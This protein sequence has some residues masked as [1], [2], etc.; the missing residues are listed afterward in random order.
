MS[1]GP[2]D[3]PS[4]PSV[5]R[6]GRA[7]AAFGGALVIIGGWELVQGFVAAQVPAVSPAASWA[8]PAILGGIPIGVVM[9]VDAAYAP[10]GWAFAGGA[11]ACFVLQTLN[12][13]LIIQ[14]AAVVMWPAAGLTGAIVSVPHRVAHL[15][16]QSRKD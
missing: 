4:K 10:W 8:V 15:R 7:C 16:M 12:V 11:V 2:W 1:P 3:R 13:P 6:I 14:L 5:D 9:L